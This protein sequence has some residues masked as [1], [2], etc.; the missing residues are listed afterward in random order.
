MIVICD[1]TNKALSIFTLVKLKI[2][3]KNSKNAFLFQKFKNIK[4]KE[5]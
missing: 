3:I 5:K 2:L 1:S 4:I